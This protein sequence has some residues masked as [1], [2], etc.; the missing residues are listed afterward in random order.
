MTATDTYSLD[1]AQ[2]GGP[3]QAR[4]KGVL[5]CA[6]CGHESPVGG[7]WLLRRDEDRERRYCPVCDAVVTDR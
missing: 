5:F 6:E 3:S 2:S 1:R 4:Q 7:D